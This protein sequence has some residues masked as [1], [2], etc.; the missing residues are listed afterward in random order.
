V[1]V[2][3]RTPSLPNEFV[4]EAQGLPLFVLFE[5]RRYDV[6]FDRGQIK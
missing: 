3:A 6:P 5:Y 1:D 2:S 4:D